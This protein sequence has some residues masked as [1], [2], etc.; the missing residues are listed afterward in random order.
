MYTLHRYAS[1]DAL[2]EASGRFIIP[3]LLDSFGEEKGPSIALSGGSSPKPVYEALSRSTLHWPDVQATLVD[4]RWVDPGEA[5]SNADFIR[6]TLLTGQ[7]TNLPFTPLKTRHATPAEGLLEAEDRLGRLPW[8]LD[9]AVLGMGPDGHT[10]SW[11]PH[12]EGLAGALA[13]VGPRLAAVRAKP[14]AVTGPHLDRM[15][16]TLGALMDARLLLMLINGPEKMATLEQ[17]IASGPVE[18]LPVRALLHH[19]GAHVHILW[20]P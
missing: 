9:V 11:F 18:D 15:T 5:G 14:S 20:C 4:E 8:P 19:E 2:V 1:R 7:A 12:A 17:A 10:A 6:E 3:M 16:L 13:E